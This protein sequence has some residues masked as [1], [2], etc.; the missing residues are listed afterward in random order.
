MVPQLL[1]IVVGLIV[2]QKVIQ[3]VNKEM[4]LRGWKC[5]CGWFCTTKPSF[6]SLLLSRSLPKFR[7]WVFYFP[8]SCINVFT[9]QKG[10]YRDLL[11]LM[12]T[13]LNFWNIFSRFIINLV[14]YFILFNKFS[15]N[16]V[17]LEFAFYQFHQ[18]LLGRCYM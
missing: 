1:F 2:F 10:P 14:I 5:L 7:N 18:H 12:S 17:A 13:L 4:H 6:K 3:V 15:L 11:V 8:A 9:Q 16:P